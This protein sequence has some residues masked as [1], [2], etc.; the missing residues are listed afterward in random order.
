MVV[1]RSDAVRNDV[2][3][4]GTDDSRQRASLPLELVVPL[5][6]AGLH[7]HPAAELRCATTIRDAAEQVY[8]L[9]CDAMTSEDEAWSE[10]LAG[11][12]HAL[13]HATRLLGRDATIG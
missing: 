9:W 11:A 4:E 1:P 8:R 13:H 12:S 6:S 5:P 3:P 2:S 7:G 10:R